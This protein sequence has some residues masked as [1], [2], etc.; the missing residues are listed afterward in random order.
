[1]NIFGFNKTPE[2]EGFSL[3]RIVVG[4]I[5]TNAYLLINTK[6]GEALIADPG[7]EAGRIMAALKRE[8]ASPVAILL[9][10]GHFDHICADDALRAHYGIPVYCLDKEAALM[11]DPRAN[12]SALWDGPVTLTPDR[13]FFP[14]QKAELAGLTF[15]V[16][17]TPGH[18]AG[19][20]CYYFPEQKILL[21]GGT[22]F[23]GSYGRTDLETGSD[24]DIVRSV[25]R[26]LK[27]LPEDTTVCP[28]HMDL[29][30][31]AFERRFNPLSE[32]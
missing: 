29:T 10:H 23:H 9:T 22:L 6:S 18:T 14:E 11:E 27:D 13:T 26:L 19:S 28:G 30:F 2:T 8:N 17:H 1:M 3:K 16:M 20:C 21:S 31:I 32:G 15:Q 24:T 25:R 4:P 5:G 7:D 12:G